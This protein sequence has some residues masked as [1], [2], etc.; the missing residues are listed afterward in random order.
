MISENG[1]EKK[2]TWER[3]NNEIMAKK[4]SYTTE[5]SVMKKW[6]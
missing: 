2:T 6:K 5:K 4:R 3:R 1:E